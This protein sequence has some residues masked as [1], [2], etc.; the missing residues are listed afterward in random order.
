MFEASIRAAYIYIALWLRARARVIIGAA[1]ICICARAPTSMRI[2]SPSCNCFCALFSFLELAA[3]L[4]LLC[5]SE[6]NY[7]SIGLLVRNTSEHSRSNARHCLCVCVCVKLA[8]KSKLFS[9]FFWNGAR[10]G[11]WWWGGRYQCACVGCTDKRERDL[12]SLSAAGKREHK[13]LFAACG[14]NARSRTQTVKKI[15]RARH[16]IIALLLALALN[17]WTRI[18]IYKKRSAE[19]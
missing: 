19:K 5:V 10:R 15:P 7:K 12:S 4:V 16:V 14:L 6:I 11:N 9:L 3:L 18:D 2:C 17:L 13:K 1:A 8:H